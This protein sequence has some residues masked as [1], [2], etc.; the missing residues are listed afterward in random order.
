[1]LAVNFPLVP[2]SALRVSICKPRKKETMQEMKEAKPGGGATMQR[3][4]SV[5]RLKEKKV[6]DLMVEKKRL[7]EVPY[8][9]SLAHTMNTLVANKAVAVPVA[10]PPGQWIGAGGSMIVESDKHTG[11]VRKHFIGMV[12]MLDIVA[13]IA[14]DDHLSGGRDITQDLDQRM[15]DPVSS[16]IGHSFEGLSLWT[17]NPNTSLLDCMEVFSKGV[18][19]AMVPVESQVASVAAGVELVESA[20]SY[21]MLTQMDVL[22]FLNDRAGEPH[23]ILSR[24][25]QDLGG[26]TQQIYA[27]TDCTK[28]VDA[29]KC[30]KAAMLNAVPIVRVS[31]ACE[32]DH[33]QLINGRCRKLVGTFSATDLRGCHLSTLKSWL[34]VSAL[35]FTE[36]VASSLLFTES[37]TQNRASARRELVTCYAESPLSEVIEK[38]V[39]MHVHRVWVVDHQG[40]LSGVV[41]LT[42]VIRVMRHSLLS[43]SD[44][45]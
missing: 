10:A 4:E 26:D 16:I 25:V 23:N 18:H 28:L 21:Q 6:M 33:K 20:S 41:S 37:D 35:A 19:H 2:I 36:E 27:I 29:I 5:Q 45:L 13:H 30:L 38:A 31:D 24:S 42:D 39:T 22:N 8:T 34:G 17:L 3:S 9:A 43:D 44:D 15:S 12:T 14:G 1:M 7:V 32:D 40:L 11:E